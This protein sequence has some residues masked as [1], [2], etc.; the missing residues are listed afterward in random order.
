DGVTPNDAL[1]A[2]TGPNNMQNYPV[3]TAAYTD[4]AGTTVRGILNSKPNTTFRIEFFTSTA[5]DAS[6]FGE[7]RQYLGFV[8][9]TTDGQGNADYR[10]E[11]PALAAGNFITATAT[12]SANS[13]SEFSSAIGVGAPASFVL[14][15]SDH[16]VYINLDPNPGKFGFAKLVAPG[17]FQSIAAGAYGVAHNPVVFGLGS[18]QKV[19]EARFDAKG[20]FVDGWGLVAPGAFQ[21]IAVGSYASDNR[22]MLFGL[23]TAAGGNKVYA[24]RFDNQGHL[25]SG[26]FA[27]A[28]GS[29]S[30]IAVGNYGLGKTEVF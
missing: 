15:Q 1:D 24:A 27:V 13:T 14:G 22:P 7:G 20:A 28:P 11:S 9:A 21:T 5:V 10:K 18:D 25:L 8:S 23:G 29:F 6:G 2:D 3:L 4:A 17:V 16:Q 30:S 19:Y 26:W 12:D